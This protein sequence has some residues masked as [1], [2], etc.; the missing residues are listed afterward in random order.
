M[1]DLSIKKVS[2]VAAAVAIASCVQA[3]AHWGRG[4]GGGWG[5]RGW[6]GGWGGGWG[7]PYG[8]GG[9]WGG[10]WGRPWGWGGGWGRRWGAFSAE[11]SEMTVVENE[12][13]ELCILNDADEIVATLVAPDSRVTEHDDFKVTP[14][15]DIDADIDEDDEED[16][17]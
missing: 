10:G 13:G 5:R 16:D 1:F 11:G 8:W 17:E 6:G 15:A 7:R 4:W 14:Y 3:E 9:G 2:I 12:G